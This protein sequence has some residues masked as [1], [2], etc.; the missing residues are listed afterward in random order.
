LPVAV[1]EEIAACRAIGINVLA[2]ATNRELKYKFDFFTTAAAEAPADDFERGKLYAARLLHPGGCNAAPGALGNLLQ[3]AGE[4]VQLRVD[5]QARELAITDPKLFHYHLV[6]MHGRNDFRLTPAERKALREYLDRGGMLFA[7]AICSSRQ[8]TEAF[9]REMAA[10]F[11]D[12]QLARIPAKDPLFTTTFGG[13]DLSLVERREPE[14]G[15]ADGPLRSQIS[16]VE[17]YLQAIKLGDRYAVIF[18]PYDL[19]CALENHESLDCAGYTRKDAAR[20]GLNVLLYSLY[21]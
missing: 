20:I 3:T 17:P 14:R 2:Y 6:F 5:P 15:A 1:R 16:Q 8:F 10:I 19:S 11:P 12:Q 18:S 4:K 7:D 21:Q 9:T 13:D